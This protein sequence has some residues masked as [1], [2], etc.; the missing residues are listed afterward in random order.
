MPRR[1]GLRRAPLMVRIAPEVKA[2]LER[3][4]VDA[5]D[6]VAKIVSRVIDAGLPVV[7]REVA[8]AK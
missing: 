8:A 1:K 7:E 3:I 4:A 5:D 2:N 6:S